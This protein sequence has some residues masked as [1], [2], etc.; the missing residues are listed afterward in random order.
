MK[1]RLILYFKRHMS[2]KK[3][4]EKLL[5]DKYDELHVAWLKRVDK[6]EQS[7]R[8]KQRESKAREFY[9]K[10]FPELRKQRE[11]RERQLNKQ[12][13]LDNY[14]SS[15]NTRESHGENQSMVFHF[16]L[17]LFKIKH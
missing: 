10:V 9:E 3:Q 7:V 12:T 5:S 16:C 13:E 4:R 11:E 1:K 17:N 2:M 8:R 6:S 15:V 14:M